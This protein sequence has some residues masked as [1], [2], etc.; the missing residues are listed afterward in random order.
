M[1]G[2]LEEPWTG[3]AS[4]AGAA[5][6]EHRKKKKRRAEAAAPARFACTAHRW[7]LNI[8]HARRACEA[9]DL[10]PI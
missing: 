9:A 1:T 4:H 10:R 2:K 3:A 6:Q 7:T 5:Q 8:H